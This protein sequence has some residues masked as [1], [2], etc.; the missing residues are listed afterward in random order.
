MGG[1]TTVQDAG[2]LPFCYK[3]KPPPLS[4][5]I[6]GKLKHHINLEML[7]RLLMKNLEKITLEHW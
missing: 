2:S 4:Y 6:T 7:K 5:L 1:A 3:Y